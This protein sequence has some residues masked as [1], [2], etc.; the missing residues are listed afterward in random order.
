M[1]EFARLV[2]IGEMAEARIGK[3]TYRRDPSTAV[4]KIENQ[5]AQAKEFKRKQDALSEL[6]PEHLA[7]AF[8]ELVPHPEQSPIPPTQVP[9]P[10]QPTAE[11][12]RDSSQEQ[13]TAPLRRRGPLP[14]ADDEK[15][16]M[17][18]EWKSAQGKETQEDFCNRKGI[19]TSTL[20]VWI[21]ELRARNKLSPR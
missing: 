11:Q 10:D 14:A 18:N 16:K 8:L 12:T 7:D 3:E 6:T 19:G 4:R 13:Q 15:E 20:R 17:I 1:S 21:R 2:C 5:I 9:A